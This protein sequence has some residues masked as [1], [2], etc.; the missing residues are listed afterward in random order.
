MGSVLGAFVSGLAT[1]KTS[2]EKEASAG[3]TLR[4]GVS[5]CADDLELSPAQREALRSFLVL[6]VVKLG[7]TSETASDSETK[8]LPLDELQRLAEVAGLKPLVKQDLTLEEA[9]YLLLK[10]GVLDGIR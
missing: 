9:R 3:Q 4:Q 1:R 10:L 7:T 8:P 2:E 6:L 5:L